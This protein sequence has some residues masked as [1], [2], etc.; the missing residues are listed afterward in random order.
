MIYAFYSILIACT[1]ATAFL[2][3]GNFDDTL[4]GIS[5]FIPRPQGLNEARRY[6]GIHPFIYQPTKK[7]QGLF[8][9]TP[10][11][12]QSVRPQ[13]IASALF[14]SAHLS[15]S[16][17][18]VPQRGPQDLLADYFGLSPEFASF[19]LLDPIIRTALF[20]F[21]FYIDMPCIYRGIYG[22]VTL[23]AG[24]TQWD[25]RLTEDIFAPGTATPFPPGYVTS[26][27]TPLAAPFASFIDAMK[28]NVSY[29]AIGG[30]QR[31]KIQ[32]R[33]TTGAAD[34]RLEFGW[35][36][37]LHD[38][39]H[40]GVSLRAALPTG[41]R[42]HGFFLFEPLLGNRRNAEIGIG[43][44]GHTI[45]W[46]KDGQQQLNVYLDL[47][48]STLLASKQYRSFDLQ[49]NG[50][51]SRYIPAKLFSNGSFTGTAAPLI[52]ST[53]LECKVHNNIQADGLLMLAYTYN[54]FVFDFGYEGWIRSKEKVTLE[55]NIAANTFG[56]KGIQQISDP[57]TGFLAPTTQSTAT[58]L[59]NEFADQMLVV[60]SP[61]PVFITPNNIDRHSAKTQLLLTNK[62]F[63]YIG[64][65]YTCEHETELFLP[66]IGV[67][68]EIEFEGINERDTTVFFRTAES[69][70]AIWVRLGANF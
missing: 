44:S 34:M 39:C 12:G 70:W 40:A 61:S 6:A 69:Q 11:Y 23:P 52:N 53:T 10:V 66:L 15:I 67:G 54:N 60:D 38:L 31:G 33:S 29:G 56:L 42:P 46:E 18:Q 51:A 45:V 63:G 4:R 16:G 24:W 28:G 5:V 62:F 22:R 14:G 48:L 13:R 64:Y 57:V 1:L 49:P 36:F 7:T 43:F 41:T 68:A 47:T 21:D 55:N 59:G 8:F 26:N 37:F 35:N 9:V 25:L 65:A 17:S 19:V 2:H 50:F 58:I 30:L 27:A 3:G 32:K 20:E